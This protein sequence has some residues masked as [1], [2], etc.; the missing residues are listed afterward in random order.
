[1]R[2]RQHRPFSMAAG[3]R[4]SLRLMEP[5]M[6]CPADMLDAAVKQARVFA[7]RRVRQHK[8]SCS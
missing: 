5:P 4:M 1:M 2:D 8:S 6:S 3:F 7:E